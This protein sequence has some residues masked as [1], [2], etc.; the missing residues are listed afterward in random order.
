M[1]NKE[2]QG[3]LDAIKWLKSQ[4]KNSDQTGCMDYCGYCDKQ[5]RAYNCNLTQEERE[6]SYACATAY[7]R[8]KQLER[9]KNYNV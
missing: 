3:K 7:N 1:T 5:S 9:R 2:R 6:N 8:M 4:E